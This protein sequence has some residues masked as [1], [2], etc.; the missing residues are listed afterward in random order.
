M[1]QQIVFFPYDQASDIT[2]YAVECCEYDTHREEL[3]GT[4]HDELPLH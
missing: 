3:D 2:L 1:A 4:S